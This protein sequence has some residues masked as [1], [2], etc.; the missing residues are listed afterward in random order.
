MMK[1]PQTIVIL[2]LQLLAL[3]KN[4]H[5]LIGEILSILESVMLLKSYSKRILKVVVAAEL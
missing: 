2:A 1:C 5:L 3:F 4:K